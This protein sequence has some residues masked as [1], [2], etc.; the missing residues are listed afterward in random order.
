MSRIVIIGAGIVGLSVARAALKRGHDIVVLEQG[1][2]PNPQAASFD[3]HRMIRYPYGSAAG[4]TRMVTEAF[5][6]WDRLW[7]DLGTVH[8]ENTG[9]IAISLEAGDY[10]Q[11]TLDTFKAV[12]LPHEVLSRDGVEALCPHLSLPAHAWGVVS[13]P[14]GPLFAGRIVTELAQWVR[15]HGGVI[16]HDC[17][18]ARVDLDAGIAIRADGSEVAGD[19]LLVAAGAWLPALLPERYGEA[20][21]Y[22]QG[23]CYVEP[24]AQYEQSWREAPAIAAIGD[25]TGYTLPDRRGAGLKI[26]YSAHRRLARPEKDGFGSDL[27]NESRAILGAFKPYFRDFEAYRPT[28]IQVGYYVLDAARRFEVAQTGRGLVVTNCDGQM[29]KFGPLLG[30]RILRMFA[31]EESAN[32]LAHWAAGY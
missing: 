22:R 14:G 15:D 29:F 31:G 6:A 1:P 5:A 7:S 19:L 30:E 20:S 10:A 27:E 16:E 4:Y 26:G 17:R 12:G 23:L 21:V 24:P 9:A 2:A 28:R 18:V 11:K 32:D 25:H 8:F 3:N 13:F